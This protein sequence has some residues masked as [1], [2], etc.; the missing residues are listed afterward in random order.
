MTKIE[1]IIKEKKA[2]FDR[3]QFDKEIWSSRS[4]DTPGAQEFPPRLPAVSPKLLFWRTVG[5]FFTH[6]WPWKRRTFS[7]GSRSP[8]HGM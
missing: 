3:K 4:G 7:P 1:R 6:S 8:L 5:R 2:S